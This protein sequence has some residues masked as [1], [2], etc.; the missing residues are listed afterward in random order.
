MRVRVMAR[1]CDSAQNKLVCAALHILVILRV[2]FWVV[3]RVPPCAI[4][5]LDTDQQRLV[6]AMV[7]QL[8]LAL[9]SL[10]DRDITMQE[11]STQN[12]GRKGW[13]SHIELDR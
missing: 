12:D 4:G 13:Q 10:N 8:R 5:H 6:P 9:V 11:R 2:Q 1:E 7:H 3:R